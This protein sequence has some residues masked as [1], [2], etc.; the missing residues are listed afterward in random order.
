MVLFLVAFIAS[1]VPSTWRCPKQIHELV[2]GGLIADPLFVH[3]GFDPGTDGTGGDNLWTELNQNWLKLNSVSLDPGAEGPDSNIDLDL[4]AQYFLL[5]GDLCRLSPWHYG[6]DFAKKTFP[7]HQCRPKYGILRFIYEYDAT[8][9]CT[10][11][12]H[13]LKTFS[14]FFWNTF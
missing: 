8:N 9:I 1:L 4:T 6:F 7:F 5:L 12:K 10:Y 11:R 14:R 13:L 2:P 3:S